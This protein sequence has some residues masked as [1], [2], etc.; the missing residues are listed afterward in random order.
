V[1]VIGML[2]QRVGGGGHGDEDANGQS[3]D[4]RTDPVFRYKTTACQATEGAGRPGYPM[5]R[6]ATDDDDDDTV[7][8]TCTGAGTWASL[9]TNAGARL[10]RSLS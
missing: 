5:V 2:A 10:V 3:R 8:A 1:G 7:P 6:P 9:R 4:Q